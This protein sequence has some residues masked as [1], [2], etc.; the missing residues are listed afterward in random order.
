M[1][2][3]I[4]ERRSA[5]GTSGTETKFENGCRLPK[6]GDANRRV[7]SKMVVSQLVPRDDW[8]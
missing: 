4:G 6:A 1:R 5:L 7:S 2:A 8:R 3:V